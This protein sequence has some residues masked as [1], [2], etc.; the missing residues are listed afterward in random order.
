MKRLAGILVGAA[1]LVTT[2]CGPRVL[3][4]KT[5]DLEPGDAKALTLV[6][7]KKDKK[8]SVEVKSDGAPVDVYLVL[9]KDEKVGL[10]GLPYGKKPPNALQSKTKV[11]KETLEVT[12][13][14]NTGLSI[15][16]FNSPE[17]RKKAS[18]AVKS[19]RL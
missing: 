2:G 3:D 5:F 14:E 13:P 16:I 4:E 11:E 1:L 8:I 7:L 19:S 10:D 6:D 12:M 9:E 15:L 17:N 18:V